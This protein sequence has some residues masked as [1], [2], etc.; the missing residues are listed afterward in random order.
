MMNNFQEGKV[1]KGGINDKPTTPRPEPPKGQGG[2]ELTKLRI[3]NEELRFKIARI[4]NVFFPECTLSGEEQ[5]RF[6][7]QVIKS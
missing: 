2:I 3:E 4:E 1:R 7:Y 6:I 5:L